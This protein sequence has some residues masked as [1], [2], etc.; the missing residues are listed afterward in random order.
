MNGREAVDTGDAHRDETVVGYQSLSSYL[1]CIV[2]NF[3]LL[4]FCE[5]FSHKHLPGVITL[6]IYCCGRISLV[7]KLFSTLIMIRNVMI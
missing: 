3:I 1:S 2:E 5:L 4:E 6:K 7:Q